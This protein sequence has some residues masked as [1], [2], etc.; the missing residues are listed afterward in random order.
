VVA[1]YTLTGRRTS[2]HQASLPAD[3]VG[4]AGVHVSRLAKL[5]VAGRGEAAVVAH[6]FGL[7]KQ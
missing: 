4:D 6:R 1:T 7:D 2:R 5:G 3:G